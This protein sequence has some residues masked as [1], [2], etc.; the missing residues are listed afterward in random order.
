MSL[1]LTLL[2]PASAFAHSVGERFGDFYGGM[3][4][5]VT[6]LE[7]LL[8][9]IAIGLLAG[10]QEP[11]TARWMLL[12]FPLGLLIG[13]LYA[14]WGDP[15]PA[16][17]IVNRASFVVIGALV[18]AAWPVPRPLLILI[19]LLF[20]LTH[21]YENGAGMTP[22][23]SWHLYALGVFLS[24]VSAVAIV[25]AVTVSLRAAWQQVAARVVGSWI[26]AIGV[27]MLGLA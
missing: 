12:A 1:A 25:A 16:A 22:G 27:L 17:S 14:F 26:T 2:L 20:G 10:Q 7:H 18:A 24:G 5:P 8:A 19:S 13:C 23:L 21:G 6:A 3:L 15:V 4:H 9:F 11:K